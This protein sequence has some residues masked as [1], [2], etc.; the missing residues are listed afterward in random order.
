MRQAV[1]HVQAIEG[2]AFDA[3]APL[4]QGHHGQR[5]QRGQRQDERGLAFRMGTDRVDEQDGQPENQQ[6]DLRGR[7][8]KIEMG[9]HHCPG[10]TVSRQ[11]R[12]A[13]GPRPKRASRR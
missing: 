12:V 7:Q 3:V 6:Q 4:Q 10:L 2:L 13:A 9:L 1:G 5:R 11:P 8:G